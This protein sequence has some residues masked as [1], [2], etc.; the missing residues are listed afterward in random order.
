VPCSASLVQLG[1]SS[2]KTHLVLS[3]PPVYDLKDTDRGIVITLSKSGVV[4]A[5]TGERP[6]FQPTVSFIN[7]LTASGNVYC[8]KVRDIA[9]IKLLLC[10]G[11]KIVPPRTSTRTRNACFYGIFKAYYGNGIATR[12]TINGLEANLLN[13]CI[14]PSTKFIE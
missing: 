10:Q 12:A 14:V 7:G 13:P 9:P 5:P 6:C 1:L 4:F 8:I 2:R 3:L 11:K